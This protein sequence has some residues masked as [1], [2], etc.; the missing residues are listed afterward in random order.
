MII[1]LSY[2]LNKYIQY[3]HVWKL[4][5]VGCLHQRTV[6]AL[7]RLDRNGKL[8]KF[9]RILIKTLYF[10]DR[11]WTSKTVYCILDKAG[12][13]REEEEEEHGQLQSVMRFM[14]TQ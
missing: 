4:F 6:I 9:F 10:K 8:L 7:Y 1:D 12:K 14:Q 5:E 13:K 3:K 2:N 11:K